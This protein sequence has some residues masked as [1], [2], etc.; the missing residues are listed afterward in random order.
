MKLEQLEQTAAPNARWG[1]TLL[2]FGQRL[3]YIGGWEEGGAVKKG[4]STVLNVEQEHERRRR[5]DDEYSAK[6]NRER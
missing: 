5:Q 6:L 4:K 1:A 2:A 3:M